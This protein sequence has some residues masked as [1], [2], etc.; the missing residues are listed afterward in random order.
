M[1]FSKVESVQIVTDKYIS[2]LKQD[3]NVG[4]TA[5]LEACS[6]ALGG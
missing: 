5:F 3:Q 2:R 6:A 1:G 4:V